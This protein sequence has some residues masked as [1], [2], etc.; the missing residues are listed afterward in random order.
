M[1]EKKMLSSEELEKV[2]GGGGDMS[3]HLQYLVCPNCGL[4]V[5]WDWFTP[6]DSNTYKIWDSEE[7]LSP[8][9]TLYCSG[10]NCKVGGG[11]F[12]GEKDW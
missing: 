5:G 3:Y 7:S 12:V 10:C 9:N 6:N 4:Q 1:D 2:S 11:H 8:S